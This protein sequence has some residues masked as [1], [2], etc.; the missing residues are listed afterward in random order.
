MEGWAVHV[1]SCGVFIRILHQKHFT[2]ICWTSIGYNLEIFALNFN[3]FAWFVTVACGPNVRNALSRW[4]AI[5]IT[6]HAST[7]M[8]L[9]AQHINSSYPPVVSTFPSFTFNLL[10]HSSFLKKKSLCSNKTFHPTNHYSCSIHRI[11]PIVLCIPTSSMHNHH[12]TGKSHIGTVWT[13][14]NRTFSHHSCQ[15]CHRHYR[16]NALV[17]CTTTCPAT[18]H[19]QRRTGNNHIGTLCAK[20]N[21][22]F[23]RHCCHDSHAYHRISTM[24]VPNTLVKVWNLRK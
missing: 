9:V 22:T 15:D 6:S 12:Q 3:C 11:P 2:F 20:D 24:V 1:E 7:F 14:G 5:I 18:M 13:K 21:R 17:L 23:S 10:I 19:N 16:I 4:G 8:T